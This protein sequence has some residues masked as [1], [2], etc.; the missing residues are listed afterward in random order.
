[1]PPHST[2]TRKPQSAVLPRQAVPEPRTEGD[3]IN[4]VFGFSVLGLLFA[5]ILS[6]LAT[7]SRYNSLTLPLVLMSAPLAAM[8]GVGL[9]RPD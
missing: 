7:D 3:S 2:F 6:L 4:E 1:M 8:L 5:C 9:G